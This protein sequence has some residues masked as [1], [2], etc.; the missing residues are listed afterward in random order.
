MN[1]AHR[2]L[3]SYIHDWLGHHHGMHELGKFLSGSS[4]VREFGCLTV[5]IAYLA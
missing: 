5:L 1:T 4:H 2:V 3:S